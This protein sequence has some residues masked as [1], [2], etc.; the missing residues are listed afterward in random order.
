M[1]N[2]NATILS[3]GTTLFACHRSRPI[4]VVEYHEGLERQVVPGAP[5]LLL[6][7]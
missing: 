4:E 1:G 3:P 6:S 2:G 5:T 7:G